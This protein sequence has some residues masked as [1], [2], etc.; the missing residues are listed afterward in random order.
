MPEV[1]LHVRG[2]ALKFLQKLR[3]RRPQNVMNFVDLVELIVAG[4]ERE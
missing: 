3:A 4:E 2:H 1:E